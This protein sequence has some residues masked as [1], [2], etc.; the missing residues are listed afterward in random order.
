LKDITFIVNLYKEDPLLVSNFYSQLR[1]IYKESAV[2]FISDGPDAIRF[3]DVN[4]V[5]ENRLKV[6]A[7]TGLWIQRYL[8]AGIKHTTTPFYIKI[9][10]DAIVLKRLEIPLMGDVCGA[11]KYTPYSPIKAWRPHAGAISFSREY[12][13]RLLNTK[14][15]EDKIYQ[16]SRVYKEREESIFADV[17][18]KTGA[19]MHDRKDFCCGTLRARERGEHSCFFHK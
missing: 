4:I 13:L 16:N 1:S 11:K 15:L 8:T 7:S 2:I 14:I 19:I 3:G 10:P 18:T 9:D 12:I 5:G 6:E 17:F